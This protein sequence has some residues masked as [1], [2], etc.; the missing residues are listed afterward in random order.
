[1]RR[2]KVEP[3]IES[4]ISG[5]YESVLLNSD[6]AL[7]EFSAIDKFKR[8]RFLL[9]RWEEWKFKPD[10][11][12]IP[13]HMVNFTM[14]DQIIK[15]YDKDSKYLEPF[16]YDTIPP[17]EMSKFDYNFKV[18][19][20][21]NGFLRAWNS[22][23][24]MY[25][26]FRDKMMRSFTTQYFCHYLAL[27]PK[28]PFYED[29]DGNI[30]IKGSGCRDVAVT[31]RVKLFIRTI[32]EEMTDK[33]KPDLC[34]ELFIFEFQNPQVNTLEIK[35]M[36]AKVLSCAMTKS[37]TGNLCAWRDESLTSFIAKPMPIVNKDIT[38]Y[39]RL[40]DD[41][42][43]G[44]KSMREKGLPVLANSLEKLISAKVDSKSVG[45]FS[46]AWF[47]EA[48]SGFLRSPFAPMA[49]GSMEDAREDNIYRP[50][51]KLRPHY[52]KFWYKFLTNYVDKI[53]DTEDEFVLDAYSNLTTRSNGLNDYIKVGEKEVPNPL[54]VSFEVDVGV[55]TTKLR[56][57]KL[58]DKATLFRYDPFVLYDYDNMISTLTPD[59]PGRLFMRHVPA[60]K[61]RMVY[62]IP[63]QRFLS[64]A[65]VR[66]MVNWLA[67]Q[68][69]SSDGISEGNPICTSMIDVGRYLTDMGPFLRITGNPDMDMMIM[70]SDFDAY[71]QTED[72]LNF[73]LAAISALEQVMTDLSS[74][75]E[76]KRYNILGGRHPLEYLKANWETLGNAYFR[77]YTSLSK[78]EEHACAFLYSGENATYVTNTTANWAF[79]T[80][81]IEEMTI[82]TFDYKD[83]TYRISDI[84]MVD[85]FKL[86]GDDQ[87]AV[88]RLKSK[89]EDVNLRAEAQRVLIDLAVEVAKSGNLRI[90]PNK[91]ELRS[92]YFEF[93]KKAGIWGYAVPRYMQ[94]SLEEQESV[95]RSMD[96]MDRMRARIGQYREYEFRGGN[97][98]W[99]K[100]RRYLEWNIIRKVRIG[101]DI[102]GKD[103]MSELP[104]SM[105]WV[106]LSK[107]GIGMHPDTVVDP[108]ADIMISIYPWS[109]VV[110]HN[111]NVVMAAIDSAPS[112]DNSKI[113]DQVELKLSKGI[114]IEKKLDHKVH[115]EK[116]RIAQESY[117]YL[118]DRGMKPDNSAYHIRYK[119]E[120]RE[121]IEDD[122]KMQKVNV[123]WKEKRARYI[124]DYYFENYEMEFTDVL[125]QMFIP[126]VSFHLG[127]VID[128]GNLPF[129]PV[130]GLDPYLSKWLQQVGTS[131]EEKVISGSGFAKLSA[132][133]NRGNFPR[134]LKA[135]NME[136]I[137]QSLLKYGYTSAELIQQFLLMRGADVEE[138]LAVANEL[139]TK[140]DLLKYLSDVSAFSFVSEGF[141][142]KSKERIDQL[143][144]FE[145]IEFDT[146]H[147][148]SMLIKSLG[149]QYM[150][151]QP[152]WVKNGNKIEINPRR[153][154]IIRTTEATRAEFIINTAS[155]SIGDRMWLD[156]I[157]ETVNYAISHEAIPDN[158]QQ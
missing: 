92:G 95:N 57:W 58:S 17:D 156:I 116:I 32:W 128:N 69:Y 111:M 20:V 10:Y 61:T 1:V 149:Y 13:K 105:I 67:D 91:T 151:T 96:P 24:L 102:T 146:T 26:M 39:I 47:I 16:D 54:V 90:S 148:F 38:T 87:I 18:C 72:F 85:R 62:G 112:K 83:V 66:D 44:L 129:C 74:V 82:K 135:N 134:N 53:P 42:D 132:L 119:Q 70:L 63:I 12:H 22:I 81:W 41:V 5:D 141:T 59:N 153:H 103:T 51:S 23:I 27:F 143:I 15:P 77:V 125:S 28:E 133:L 97:T 110:R 76:K 99:S 126:G 144:F 138:S 71:D 43:E 123:K 68:R 115:G 56:T 25:F 158:L 6:S 65:F 98:F 155:N 8:W 147:P 36:K 52:Q 46:A 31:L 75:L 3:F 118:L 142:D 19:S 45:F 9:D 21:I 150:R 33:L 104:F 93:L 130:A 48:L 114:D 2:T 154:V 30:I 109:D 14:I 79:V 7:D 73:R 88:I 55:D 127:E 124:I 117:Q 157:R 121:A 137:A 140:M 29:G 34:T 108:N 78:S 37:N 64:E 50:E 89:L 40:K 60:R 84:F 101:K 107:G 86:Q 139:S 106:P 136:N 80:A 35:N 49:I 152:L 113:V 120:V 100:V 122:K 4:I 94:V 131:S 145:N 11:E